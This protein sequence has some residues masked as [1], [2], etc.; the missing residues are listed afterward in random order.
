MEEKN[1]HFMFLLNSTLLIYISCGFSILTSLV[2]FYYQSCKGMLF[3]NTLQGVQNLR[4]G[5]SAIPP[6]MYLVLSLILI[7]FGYRLYL[8]AVN[9]AQDFSLF[10]ARD[11]IFIGLIF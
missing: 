6:Q 11:L 1:N 8:I 4:G 7:Y 2:G 5:F 3:C 9:A 10:F